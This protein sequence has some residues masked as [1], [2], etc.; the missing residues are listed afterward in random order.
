MKNQGFLNTDIE[1][2]YFTCSYILICF[3]SQSPKL[4]RKNNT[5]KVSTLQSDDVSFFVVNNDVLCLIMTVS[6]DLFA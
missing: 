1:E 5:P 4:D 6:L 2:R 3:H